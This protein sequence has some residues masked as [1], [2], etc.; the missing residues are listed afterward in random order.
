M[1]FLTS[2]LSV[3]RRKR[4]LS[5]KKNERKVRRNRLSSTSSSS[6]SS[7]S[8]FN[9]RV[10]WKNDGKCFYRDLIV[11]PSSMDNSF[12]FLIK[13]QKREH[14]IHNSNNL[15]D[16]SFETTNPIAHFSFTTGLLSVRF[17]SSQHL[18]EFNIWSKSR[19]R[20]KGSGIY[21]QWVP[22]PR[23][24]NSSSS[25]KREVRIMTKDSCMVVIDEIRQRPIIYGTIQQFKNFAV[26]GHDI[27]M[28][29]RMGQELF[30]VCGRASEFR[31]WA[32]AAC[33]S[34]TTKKKESIV[35]FNLNRRRRSNKSKRI[36][37]ERRR[38]FQLSL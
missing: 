6:T 20:A 28:L 26:R 31:S 15:I 9:G 1:N 29:S 21:A 27:R 36:S 18:N 8:S 24:E 19:I 25:K 7:G 5:G 14:Q 34:C 35:R 4:F 22:S 32:E 2:V 17:P 30:F 12:W 3:V 10:L 11:S 37:G 23:L 16:M 13:F 38:P 33:A